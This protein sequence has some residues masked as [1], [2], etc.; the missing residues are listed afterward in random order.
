MSRIRYRVDVFKL[1]HSSWALAA[2]LLHSVRQTSNYNHLVDSFVTFKYSRQLL[3]SFRVS[4][5][6]HYSWVLLCSLKVDLALILNIFFI[7]FVS[8]FCSF[9]S[10]L[11]LLF[12]LVSS[13]YCF[14]ISTCWVRSLPSLLNGTQTSP[15]A[16]FYLPP[17]ILLHF[18]PAPVS[19]KKFS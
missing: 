17:D 5:S 1:S 7:L 3:F 4:T 10:L 6:V 2:I 11:S 8:V 18:A 15:I 12:F 16:F 14:R 9:S 19:Q 13:S